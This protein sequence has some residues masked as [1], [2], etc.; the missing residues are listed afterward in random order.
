MPERA[1]RRRALVA[2]TVLLAARPMVAQAAA[3]RVLTADLGSGPLTW[4]VTV[5]RDGLRGA[6]M[7]DDL[8]DQLTDLARSDLL[9]V[10]VLAAD[11]LSSAGR[12]VPDPPATAAHPAIT[13]ALA[14]ALAEET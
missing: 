2:A 14:D 9:S 8:A 6:V 7:A 5:L 12:Q 11:I 10:R 13:R 4:L 3:A 1:D